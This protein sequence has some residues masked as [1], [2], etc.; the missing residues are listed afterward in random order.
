[1][2]AC[3][4]I[5]YFGQ[6]DTLGIVYEVGKIHVIFSTFYTFSM[7]TRGFLNA[8][9]GQRPL[10]EW[11]LL[12]SSRVLAE[13]KQSVINILISSHANLLTHQSYGSPR[14]WEWLQTLDLFCHSQFQA[15]STKWG[16]PPLAHSKMPILPYHCC[17][18][19]THSLV[20]QFLSDHI[21]SM[22][23]NPSYIIPNGVVYPGLTTRYPF[24]LVI[25][26][27][28]SQAYANSLVG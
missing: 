25:I 9:L 4:H 2:K 24:H 28:S 7:P 20:L 1:M 18:L 16:W 26:I 23:V 3:K 19:S 8:V 27:H 5:L 12:W 6:F 11:R 15:Q 10:T 21:C 22:M 17:S 13:L 14:D